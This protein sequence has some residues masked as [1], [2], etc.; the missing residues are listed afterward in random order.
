MP[1]RTRTHDAYLTATLVGLIAAAWLALWRIDES[2][3]GHYLHVASSAGVHAHHHATADQPL[4]AGVLFTGSWMLMV[5]AMMLPTTLPLIDMFRRLTRERADRT[6]LV[7]VM[8]G[9]YLCIWGA[10]GIA[11]YGSVSALD[12]ATVRWTWFVEH[13]WIG[14]VLLLLAAGAFQFSALK[15]RC[16]EKCRSP[17]M[18]VTERWHGERHLWHAFRLG[19][20]HGA[21]CVGCCWALMLLMLAVSSSALM[22]ML[23]LGAVMAIEKNVAWGSRLA[24]PLGIVLIVSGVATLAYGVIIAG[25]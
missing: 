3:Y 8:L 7:L 22:W 2:P 19:L 23:V 6:A 9:G 20:D 18:F 12:A 24:R 5:I 11:A 17:L 13:G 1:L 16:L 10:F 14:A 15:Y 25:I 4:V 21:F